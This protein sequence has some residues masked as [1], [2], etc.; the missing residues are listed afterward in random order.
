M[1][2]ERRQSARSSTQLVAVV[3]NMATGNVRRW[4]TKNLSGLG[5]CLVADESLQRGTRLEVELTLPDAAEPLTLMAEV[6]WIMTVE[7]SRKSYEMPKVELGVRFIDPPKTTHDLL[8][9]YAVLTAA[10]TE[11]P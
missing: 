8:N 6:I 9:Q 11:L 10:P 2:Q 3:K 5:L 4:L 1:G 7:A